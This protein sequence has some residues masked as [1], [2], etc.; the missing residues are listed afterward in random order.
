[1]SFEKSAL[2]AIGGFNNDIKYRSDEKFVFLNLKKQ[3]ANIKYVPK[4]VA[5]HIIDETRQSKALVIKVSQ[6]TGAGE[7]ERL[8]RTPLGLLMKLIEYKIK[9]FASILLS[10]PFVVKGQ[11]QKAEY[12]ITSRYYV[13]KGFLFFRN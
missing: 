4:S 1:M 9:F 12:L 7:R 10:I 13:L 2:Q 11:M 5:I 6:L 8:W 3:H